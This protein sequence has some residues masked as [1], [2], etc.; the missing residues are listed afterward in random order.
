M[1]EH[2]DEAGLL[3]RLVHHVG[4]AVVE[5][6]EVLAEGRGQRVLLGDQVEHVLLGHRRREVGVEEMV[7]ELLGRRPQAL[8]GESPDRLND[9]AAH[10]TKWLIHLPRLFPIQCCR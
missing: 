3:A 5:R 10:V 9:V 2:D 6:V 4:H 1:L 7:A 8:H